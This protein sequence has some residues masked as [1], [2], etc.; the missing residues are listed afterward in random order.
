MALPALPSDWGSYDAARKIDWFNKNVVT[1]DDLVAEGVARSDIDWLIQNGLQPLYQFFSIKWNPNA[2]LAEKQNYIKTVLD[3][4]ITT[5]AIKTRLG[6][7]DPANSTQ[8]VYNLLGIPNST[9][10]LA[11]TTPPPTTPPPTTAPPPTTTAPPTTPPPTTT[12]STY[13]PTGLELK[14]GWIYEPEFAK[15]FQNP[16]TGQNLTR[17]EYDAYILHPNDIKWEGKWLSDATIQF[18][19]GQINS[20]KSLYNLNFQTP[21]NSDSWHTDDIAK[22]LTAIGITD[23]GQIGLKTSAGKEPIT[24]GDGNVVGYNDY[25]NYELFDKRTNQPLN[26]SIV[27]GKGG[28]VIGSTGAGTGY[29]NYT[30]RVDAFGSPIIV[31]E[32][33]E[34]NFLAKNPLLTQVLAM[35]ASFLVP[36]V[37]QAIAPYISSVVGAAAA[38]AVSNFLVRTAVNTVFNGGDLSKAFLGAA[39]GTALNM[40]TDV[41]ANELANSGLISGATAAEKLATAKLFAAPMTNAIYAI[42]QGQDPLPTLLGGAVNAAISS[43]INEV[44][45]AQKLDPTSKALLQ[46]GVS[47]AINTARTGTFNPVSLINQLIN[48]GFSQAQAAKVT[49]GSVP[50]SAKSNTAIGAVAIDKNGELYTMYDDGSRLMLSGNDAGKA[51]TAEE[52]QGIQ[53]ALNT[54]QA[55]YVN[56][57]INAMN[58]GTATPDEVTSDLKGSGYSDATI[59]SIFKANEQFIDRAK[60]AQDIAKDYTA[61]G[62]D[63]MPEGAI[64]RLVAAG[65]SQ[66]DA[67]KYVTNLDNQV[68]ARNNY[69]NTANDFINGK[70]TESQLESAMD[71]AGLKGD[72]ANDTL[73]TLRAIRAGSDL[74]SS[75]LTNAAVANLN[76]W[77]NIGNGRQVVFDRNTETGELYVKTAKD[78]SGK[79]ITNDF[80]GLSPQ[81]VK[82]VIDAQQI[83]QRT[84]PKITASEFSVPQELSDQA[85]SLGLTTQTGLIRN[86]FATV[87]KSYFDNLLRQYSV[88]S[89]EDRAKIASASAATT[90]MRILKD[91]DSQYKAI[92]QQ[93]QQA[94]ANNQKTLA[95]FLLRADTRVENKASAYYLDQGVQPSTA[96]ALALE[97]AQ[98]GN[99]FNRINLSSVQDSKFPFETKQFINQF[100]GS[101]AGDALANV[102]AN[103]YAVTGSA[104]ANTLNGALGINLHIAESLGLDSFAK[105]F[106]KL[107]AGIKTAGDDAIAIANA[108]TDAHKNLIGGL[109]NAVSAIPWLATGLAPGLVAGAMATTYGNE[110]IQGRMSG[111]STEDAGKRATLMAVAEGIGERIGADELVGMLKPLWRGTSTDQLGKVIGESLITQIGKYGTKEQLGELLSYSLQ[112]ATDKLPQIGLAQ[113][114]TGMDFLKGALDTMQQ[115]FVA[116]GANSGLAVG[117]RGGMT[118][119]N[120]GQIKIISPDGSQGLVELGNGSIIR[121]DL[122]DDLALNVGEQIN[123]NALQNDVVYVPDN[124]N[125]RFTNLQSQVNQAFQNELGRP[126][127]F[128]ELDFNV[129]RLADGTTFDSIVNDLNNTPDGKLLDDQRAFNAQTDAQI[130]ANASALLD[131]GKITYADFKTFMNTMGLAG[132]RQL[133]VLDTITPRATVSGTVTSIVGDN[134]I[135]T[136]ADGKMYTMLRVGPNNY[137]LQKGDVVNLGVSTVKPDATP[138]VQVTTKI[139]DVI[140]ASVSASTSLSLSQSVSE[141]AVSTS[142]SK[143]QSLSVSYSQSQSLS[144]STSVS[145]SESQSKSISLSQSVSTA[146]Y[147]KSVSLSRSV[148]TSQSISTSASISTSLSQ[149]ASTSVSA[150]VSESTSISKAVSVSEALSLSASVSEQM[151]KDRLKGLSISAS[152]SESVSKAVSVSE[153]ISKAVSVSESTSASISASQSVSK[154]TSV[155]QSLSTSVSQSESVSKATSISASVSASTS[156]SISAS[157][158]QSISLSQEVSKQVSISQSTSQSIALSQSLSQS[159][160]VSISASVSKSVSQSTSTSVSISE[161]TAASISA[162]VSQSQSLSQQMSLDVVKA[163]SVSASLSASA[164]VSQ[165]ISKLVAA[166]ISASQ[167]TSTALSLSQSVSKQTEL[168]VS[169]SLSTSAS[170]SQSQSLSVSQALS[171]S[172]SQSLSL[173]QSLSQS[174]SQSLSAAVSQSQ[175]LSTS[176]SQSTSVSQEI[177]NNRQI[178]LSISASLS[179]SLSRSQAVSISQSLSTS[180]SQSILLSQ[181]QALSLSESISISN[182]LSQEVSRQTSLSQSLSTAN[183]LSTSLSQSESLSLSQSQS[184]SPTISQTLAPTQ[185]ITQSITPSVTE[186]ITEA[187]TV[188]ITPEITEAITP[189]V[190]I[191]TA[192]SISVTVAPTQAITAEI[193]PSVTQTLTESFTPSLTMV[194]TTTSL[195]PVTTTITIPPVTSEEATKEPVTTATI[196]PVTPPP[197]SSVVTIPP[198]TMPSISITELT[199][200]IEPTT[201][202]TVTTTAPVTTTKAPTT[203]KPTTSKPTTVTTAPP[204]PLF[205]IPAAAGQQKTYVDYAQ[206]N[207]PAPQFGPFDLFK[208]PNYL[209]PLQDTGNFGLAALIGATND[210]KQGDGSNQSQQN[211]QGQNQGTSG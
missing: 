150:S 5:D 20:S 90:E 21:G 66:A 184:A 100:R 18:L 37:G 52:W 67:G 138:T 123:V 17:A 64:Q 144:A 129:K 106:N 172:T 197:T 204:F 40:V 32:W 208:A 53:S 14:E 13:K 42:S 24:D 166:S 60:K 11:T 12:T 22:R 92:D 178:G 149:S 173:S 126:P 27:G 151:E 6:E 34:S 2:T 115:T 200:T 140:A 51:Y 146:E 210:A 80:Y 202:A 143:S 117:L 44:A 85:K 190:S 171:Q 62:S 94:T 7:L 39:T 195:P 198:V 29:S 162:S 3:Q 8:E 148:S 87:Q 121:V 119:D 199:T 159:Q 9:T 186:S 120:S 110:Y 31:P 84:A 113:D 142:I 96:M 154:A 201:T 147:E 141:A 36:G 23:L 61:V 73:L 131:Q 189:T 122:P 103:A 104:V 165:S 81:G 127:T 4:G 155:S 79:D 48:L 170:V 65:F 168:S 43:G 33:K 26:T 28:N 74:T 211:A 118:A 54:G 98:S 139:A 108:S 63:M 112:A 41:V 105:D 50:D 194:I 161:A 125:E 128:A 71:A 68:T 191:T 145:V 82:T 205:G 196:P 93:R 167:S 182:Y 58:N 88:M 91:I 209:R 152:V 160:A 30:V 169:A 72:Q 207:V 49:G 193:T 38:P 56:S 70:A 116:A 25:T 69:T 177:E 181:S 111:L 132:D 133:N 86:N 175:S 76:Q 109:S 59:A 89:P 185:S 101:P 174:V 176:L 114:M 203:S 10:A 130:A 1:I 163:M 183:S 57:L 45:N 187:V 19:K 188:S 99:L 157:T 179:Q 55:N 107:A 135:V 102:L 206:P 15:P 180:Q 137:L 192:P 158:S 136:G 156:A 164:S 124:V 153:S 78:A 77:F 134:A 97:D 16:E 35:G 95:D 46:I 47:Q 83:I 75:E